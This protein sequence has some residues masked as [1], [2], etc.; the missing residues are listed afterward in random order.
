MELTLAVLLG[1]LTAISVARL[2]AAPLGRWLGVAAVPLL[3]GLGLGKLTMV[4]GGAG[5]GLYSDASYATVYLRPGPWGSTNADLAAVPSQALEG[6]LV[7]SAVVLVLAVPFLLR[8]RFL[9]WWIVV[10]PALAPRRDWSLLTGGRRFLTLLALW[11][12]ARFVAAF[13]WRDAHV[14][15][16]LGTEQLALIGL[17]ALAIAGRL[18]VLGLRRLRVGVPAR[19]AVRNER[20]ARAAE[21]ARLAA[22]ART[23]PDATSVDATSAD[24]TSADAAPG[25]EPTAQTESNP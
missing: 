8:L 11:A 5:Q 23:K 25:T 4:L 20:R 10:R 24:A 16:P 22:A 9:D 3:L 21:D 2:L 12:V 17:A 7:L 18:V 6:V 13:T 19:R 1:S 14:L 15:G